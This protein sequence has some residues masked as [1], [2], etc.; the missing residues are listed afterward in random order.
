MNRL[1]INFIAERKRHQS[2]AM[3]RGAHNAT[4][5]TTQP[6]QAMTQAHIFSEASTPAANALPKALNKTVV[7]N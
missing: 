7:H 2:H 1:F 6:T 5:N 4:L 3:P